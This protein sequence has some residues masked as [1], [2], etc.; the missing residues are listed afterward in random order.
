MVGH[1][2]QYHP[3][4]ERLKKLTQAGELGRI[5]YI[6]STASTWEK[7]GGRRIFYGPSRRMT[8]P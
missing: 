2:L 7:S 6:Y 8:S 5:N 4:F 1:L 3:V